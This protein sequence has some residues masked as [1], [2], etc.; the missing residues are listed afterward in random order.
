MADSTRPKKP[1]H[2]F[3]MRVMSIVLVPVACPRTGNQHEHQ[4]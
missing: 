4:V 1:Q 3:K 2:P